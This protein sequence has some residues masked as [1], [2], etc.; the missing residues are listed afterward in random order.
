MNLFHPFWIHLHWLFSK[1]ERLD[2]SLLEP[3]PNLSKVLHHGLINEVHGCSVLPMQ[4]SIVARV[5]QLCHARVTY[6]QGWL[7]L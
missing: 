6:L 7:W 1:H 4:N 5:D 2:E 3:M